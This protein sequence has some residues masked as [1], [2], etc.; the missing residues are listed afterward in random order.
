[1]AL[2]ISAGRGCFTVL[3]ALTVLTAQSVPRARTWH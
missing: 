2:K 1:L 3:Q